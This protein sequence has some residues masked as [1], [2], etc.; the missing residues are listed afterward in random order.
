MKE[1]LSRIIK[2]LQP[3]NEIVFGPFYINDLIVPAI[4]I[5]AYNDV[6]IN[7][8]INDEEDFELWVDYSIYNEDFLNKLKTELEKLI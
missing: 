6:E 2:C 5:N 7:C 1:T 4:R 3:E 8:I